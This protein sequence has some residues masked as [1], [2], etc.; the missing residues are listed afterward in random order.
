MSL[1]NGW[2]K[3]KLG[4]ICNKIGSG[5]TPK[6]GREV[7]LDAGIPII[8]SQNVLNGFLDLNDVAFI[9]DE[10]HSKMKGTWVH[11][12]DILLNITGASIGRSCVVPATVKTANVNQH[13]CIIRLKEC[14]DACYVCNLILSKDVQKQIELLSVGGGRQGLNFQQIASFSFLLPPLEE[15]KKIAATLSVWD[16]AIEKMEKF[17]DAKENELNIVLRQ[18][19]LG[20]GI[21]LKWKEIPLTEI[22]KSVTPPSKIHQDSYLNSGKY[23]IVDQSKDLIAGWTNDE[24]SVLKI[25]SPLIIFGDHTCALK[26]VH[27]PFAQG[28]DGIK[29]LSAKDGYDP[30][31]IYYAIKANPVI[32]EG[33]KRH[34]SALMLKSILCPSLEEQ[35]KYAVYFKSLD[36]EISLL[37]QQLENY[38][39]Q[40]QGLMQKLLTGQW[41]VK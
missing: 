11:P 18:N 7:Y 12:N 1:P 27:M 16:S 25:N 13:V 32:P 29:I 8:R 2:K 14:A 5:S 30:T 40:K 23:P 9:S 6:G 15:Q 41:R 33:Y 31:Y 17:I 36:E 34:F 21:A 38:K 37:K 28:A 22:L 26:I 3:I 35:K 39:K 10:Q 20:K 4:E 19:L 24:S